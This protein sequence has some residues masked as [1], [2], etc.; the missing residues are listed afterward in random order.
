MDIIDE[1]ESKGKIT[2]LRPQKPLVVDRM[3]KDISKLNDLYLE[4]YELAGKINFE[5]L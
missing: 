5:F 2:V 4:G 1:L 3:E